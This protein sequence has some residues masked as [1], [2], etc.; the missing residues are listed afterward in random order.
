MPFSEVSVEYHSTYIQK[1]VYVS[2]NSKKHSASKSIAEVEI[3]VH[4]TTTIS[5]GTYKANEQPKGFS[6]EYDTDADNPDLVQTKITADKVFHGIQYLLQLT[7]N[8]NQVL[9]VEI[10]AL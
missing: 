2:R 8:T 9:S 10:K 7:N 1:R 5:L 3:A 4:D 6:V